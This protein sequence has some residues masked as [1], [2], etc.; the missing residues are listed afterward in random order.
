MMQKLLMFCEK[1]APRY[2]EQSSLLILCNILQ[3]ERG[4]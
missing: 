4:K 1:L 2:V 3:T